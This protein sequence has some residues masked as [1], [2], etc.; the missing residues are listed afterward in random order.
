MK[1]IRQ[2][3]DL[4]NN[5]A[6]KHN[7]NAQILLRNYMMERLLERIAISEFKDN[8]ILKGGMLISSIVGIASRSTVDMDATMKRHELTLESIESV[9]NVFTS[10]VLDDGV[11]LS[12][13]KIK[14]IRNE[15]EYS[16]YR[17]SIEA[18]LGTANIPFK[19]DITSG[20][21]I[22]P[23]EILREFNLMLEDRS[24]HIL[25]YNIETVLAEK[26]ETILSRGT[27]NTRMRDFYDIYMLQK[28]EGEE[29][30][31]NTLNKV[32]KAT[33]NSRLTLYI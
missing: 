22:T 26:I 30:R 29:I 10:M 3:K 25:S 17:V 5:M 14:E 11:E 9:F 8:F 18:K 2:V 23:K 31:Y 19:V 6:K 4:I 13:N 33:A 21:E 15:A 32:L 24:I 7:A 20:D 1:T 16:G 12:V 27:V 28:I